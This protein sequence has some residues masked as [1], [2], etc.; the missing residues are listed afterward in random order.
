[1]GESLYWEQMGSALELRFVFKGSTKCCRHKHLSCG[2]STSSKKEISDTNEL[3]L[4]A[5]LGNTTF[6]P[7][8]IK[9][10]INL[11]RETCT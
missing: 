7:S 4:S 2:L 9:C 6:M 8:K 1:M 3:R 10:I 11:G 5:H